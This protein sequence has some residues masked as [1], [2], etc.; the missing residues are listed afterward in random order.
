MEVVAGASELPLPEPFLEFLSQNGLDPSIY[1]ASQS[2]PRYIR[3]FSLETTSSLR[4][5]VHILFIFYLFITE[6]NFNGAMVLCL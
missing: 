1:A 6:L 4:V 2:T 3:Y 5:C